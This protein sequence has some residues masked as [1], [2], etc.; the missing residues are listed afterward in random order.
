MIPT[1]LLYKYVLFDEGSLS[2][3]K[4]GTMKFT[5]ARKFTLVPNLLISQEGEALASRNRKLEL[6]NRISKIELGNLV[7]LIVM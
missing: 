6:H 3:I 2:I 7:N 1:I 5:T 4:D